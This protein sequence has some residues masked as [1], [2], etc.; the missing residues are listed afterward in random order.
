MRLARQA[1]FEGRLDLDLKK[2]VFIDES[3]ASTQLAR[4]YG[5]A[6]R[7]ER[8]R[9]ASPHATGKRPRSQP[10]CAAMASS[11][12]SCSMALWM[13]SP[14]RLR[15]GR[16]SSPSLSR[17]MSWSWITCLRTKSRVCAR[18]SKQREQDFATCHPMLRTSIPSRWPSPNLRPS[19]ARP[20]PEQSTTSGAPSPSAYQS[21]P[22]HNAETSLPP[23][24]MT[25]INLNRL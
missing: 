15:L 14:L 5:R 12:L 7:G 6:R 20:P 19:F 18:L 13:A 16:Y 23:Q 3:G 9:A 25:R 4:R 17:A 21:S 22:R 24:D 2:L 11:H 1:G 8:C 10:V